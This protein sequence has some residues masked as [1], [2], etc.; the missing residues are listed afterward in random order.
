MGQGIGVA[1]RQGFEAI[2][3]ISAQTIILHEQFNTPEATSREIKGLKNTEGKNSRQ[4]VFQ[5]IDPLEIEVGSV[6]QIKGSRDY[7]RVTDTEDI[8]EDDTFINFEVRVEKINVAG[9]PT[10]P[11]TAGGTTYNTEIHLRD[12]S[13]GVL[14]AGEI[15]D[16]QSISANV[17]SLSS[18][19]QTEIANALKELTE[20]VAGSGDLPPEER[21]H[22]LESLEELSKQAALPAN[23]R[24]KLGVIKSLALGVG[25]TVSAAGGLAEVWSTWGPAIRA[26]F[27]F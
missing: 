9:K 22:V 3:G 6:L 16:V 26:Y 14:N 12:S 8:I 13:V 25:S 11:A 20:A 21:T 4:V 5:F 17:T 2:F 1:F 18:A 23:E 19:G 15:K 27:G 10:R 7:W 24:A